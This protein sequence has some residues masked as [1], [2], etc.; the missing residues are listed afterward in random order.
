MNGGNFFV[1]WGVFMAYCAAFFI[2]NGVMD[3]MEKE[4]GTIGEYL[5]ILAMLLISANLLYRNRRKSAATLEASNVNRW[6]FEWS[7]V[8]MAYP[9]IFIANG[10]LP[11]IKQELGAI[12]EYLDLTILAM[13]FLYLIYHA[14]KKSAVDAG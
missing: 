12:G 6:N 1:R 2:L 9:M 7:Y 4:L 8:L 3:I 13:L 11:I 14:Q 5:V 10:V